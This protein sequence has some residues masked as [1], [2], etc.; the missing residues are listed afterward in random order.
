[1]PDITAKATGLVLITLLALYIS[2]QVVSTLLMSASA[3][4]SQRWMML[5]LPLIFV[6]ILIRYPA[7]LLIYWI[8]TNL[9]TIAQGY[10]VRRRIGPPPVPAGKGLPPPGSG[11]S[12][13]GKA[14]GDGGP[15]GRSGGPMGEPALAGVGP[16]SAPPPP[17]RK[18]KKRS[19]RRR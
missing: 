19:G 8:T 7:G 18:K 10:I 11:G 3:E 16:G 17:P 12:A 13:N 9:W 6:V 5:G 1:V 14:D 4:P 2:S 15:R